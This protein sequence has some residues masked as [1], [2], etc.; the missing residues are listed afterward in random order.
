MSSTS[1]YQAV[2]VPALVSTTIFTWTQPKVVSATLGW[3][4]HPRIALEARGDWFD[5][6][7]FQ[8]DKVE[9]EVE[10]F[11]ITGNIK[12]FPLIG[13][14]QPYVVT[15]IGAVNA[16]VNQRRFNSGRSSTE[17]RTEVS[18]RIGAGLD[19]FLSESIVFEVEASYNGSG[20]D[21]DFLDYGLLSAGLQFR[22]F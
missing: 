6:F 20:G 4:I 22:F 10:G 17:Q 8:S 13:R 14:F 9:G 11:A 2:A 19:V 3:R 12:L 15:G 18:G 1:L 21:L 16:E 5:G 7:D